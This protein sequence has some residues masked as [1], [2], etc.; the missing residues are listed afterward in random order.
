[1]NQ[2]RKEFQKFLPRMAEFHM[3]LSDIN[4]LKMIRILATEKEVTVSELAARLGISQ[5]AVSQHLR[6][7]KMVGLLNP[8]RHGNRT[9]YRVN[10]HSLNEF[11]TLEND[12]YSAVFEPCEDCESEESSTT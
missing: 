9:I 7:L 12:L 11:R 6:I 8:E 1:M 3:A 2:S 4:R 5:P 10:I